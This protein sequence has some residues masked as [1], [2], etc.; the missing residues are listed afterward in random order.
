[1]KSTVFILMDAFR[2]DYLDRGETPFLD[3]CKLKGKYIKKII[4]GNG[5]CE[6]AEIFTGKNSSVT[7]YFTAIGLD[8]GKSPYK[9]FAWILSLLSFITNIFKYR[10][11]DKIIRRLLWI[12]ISKTKHPMHPYRIPYEMLQYFSLTEDYIDMRQ[13][14]ALGISSFFDYLTT[15]NIEYYYDSFTA[16]NL[17]INGQ[18]EDRLKLAL[19]AASELKGVFFI[20]IGA[21]DVVGHQFGPNSTEINHIIRR[22]DNQLEEFVSN[23]ESIQP[24]SNYIFLGDHGMVG[25]EEIIDVEEIVGELSSKFNLKL[26]VDFLYFLDSTLMR[27]WFLNDNNVTIKQAFLESNTLT[28]K[29]EFLDKENS[30]AYGIPSLEKLGDIVWLA[31]PGVLICPDFFHTRSD[32]INGMH[33]YRNNI[34]ESKGFCIVNGESMTGNVIN[35]ADLTD[36][37]D[38]LVHCTTSRIENV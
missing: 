34:N 28:S 10:I 18:D 3:K 6:R 35:E 30:E 36:V 38:I 5:F 17:P 14:N 13:P 8:K 23:F 29:G 33:G 2:N 1:M 37:H 25:V 4:P 15:N 9:N 31:N 21:A 26:G 32:N 7:G 11:I 27:I 12:V 19:N 22:I 24:D 20:Y 16:L